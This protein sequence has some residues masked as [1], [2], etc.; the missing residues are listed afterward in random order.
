MHQ[1]VRWDTDSKSIHIDNCTSFSI[2]NDL[3]DFESNPESIDKQVKGIGG[4]IKDIN[5]GTFI[6]RIEDNIGCVH[7]L[8]LPG[9]LYLPKSP[10]KLLSPQH[11][12]QIVK[13]IDPSEEVQCITL[14]DKV[15]LKWGAEQFIKTVPI[16]K[17]Q[18][19]DAVF[20]TAPGYKTFAAFEQ[21]AELF[22]QNKYDIDPELTD[23]PHKS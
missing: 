15:I 20:T 1:H 7:Q 22:K 13:T 8:K 14:A 9:S 16:T 17:N 19:N 21:R 12:S 23:F 5:R 11:W 10:I 2:T 4:L 18:G 3:K 6:W